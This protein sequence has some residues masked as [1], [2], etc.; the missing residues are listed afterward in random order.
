MQNESLPPQTST[1]APQTP[2]PLTEA[3][4]TSLEELFSKDPFEFSK[5]DEEAIVKALRA[6]RANWEIAERNGATKAPGVKAAPKPKE[7]LNLDD[8]L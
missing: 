2:S 3:S 8:L 5:Q 1:P 4:P 6:Q 7:T